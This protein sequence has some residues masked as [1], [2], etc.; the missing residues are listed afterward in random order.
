MK[1]YCSGGRSRR[2]AFLVLTFLLFAGITAAS[3][4]KKPVKKV[5]LAPQQITHYH[6]DDPHTKAGFEHFYNAEYEPAIRE[7][8]MALDAHPDDPFAVNHMLT[9]IM[10]KEM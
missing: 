3:A 5:Q 4:S 1:P 6:L 10:F 9:G 2:V 7:F 8:Q